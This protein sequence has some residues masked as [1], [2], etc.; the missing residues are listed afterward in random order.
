MKKFSSYFDFFIYFMST[1]KSSISTSTLPA[2]LQ[3]TTKF[4]R[5]KFVKK[6]KISKVKEQNYQAEKSKLEN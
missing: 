4:I 6:W 1:R 3:L 5:D 2:Q